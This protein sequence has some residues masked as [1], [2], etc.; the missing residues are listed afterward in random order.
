MRVVASKTERTTSR[1]VVSSE[2]PSP[3]TASKQLLLFTIK[4]NN[5]PRVPRIVVSVRGEAS[6]V[7]SVS[8]AR[9]CDGRSTTPKKNDEDTIYWLSLSRERGV[10]G[11]YSTV[12][13]LHDRMLY[14]FVSKTPLIKQINQI[15]ES[16]IVQIR[17]RLILRT[18]IKY[19]H[20]TSF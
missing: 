16:T 4:L 12:S 14:M 6:R 5:N 1:V 20:T 18:D 9:H 8:C 10:A 13:D 2:L 19:I 15:S 17:T 3:S 11:S 7:V